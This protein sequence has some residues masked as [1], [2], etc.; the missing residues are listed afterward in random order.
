MHRTFAIKNVISRSLPLMVLTTVMR[1]DVI[2]LV[3]M[4]MCVFFIPKSGVVGDNI[5]NHINQ[6]EDY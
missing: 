1:N 3:V 4:V 5:E 2:M 6:S